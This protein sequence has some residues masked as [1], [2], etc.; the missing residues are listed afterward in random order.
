MNNKY[1][2]L[3][4]SHFVRDEN[5]PLKSEKEDNNDR[6]IQRIPISGNTQSIKPVEQEEPRVEFTKELIEIIDILE[7]EG[8]IVAFEMLWLNE[9]FAKYK[10]GLRI[11]KVDVSKVKDCYDVTM[12]NNNV[13]P[14]R[15]QNF[16]NYYWGK[17]YFDGSMIKEYIDQYNTL[18]GGVEAAPKATYQSN[19]QYKS[20]DRVDVIKP[21]G[22]RII[23]DAFKYDPKNVRSTFISLVTKTYPSGHE[24]ELLKFLPKLNKDSVGNYYKV[25]GD[26]PQTMFTCHL[27]TA[28]RNQSTTRLFS[29][30]GADGS[31]M[32]HTDGSTILGADDKAGATILLYMIAYN[33]PG[34]YYFF[35]GEERGGVGSGEISRIYDSITYL[36]NI[37]KCVSFD[38]RDVCSVITSQLGGI[39]CSREF[40]NALCKEFN[41]SG[42]NLSLDS[43]GIYTDS[44][45]FLEQI[46]EC[47]NI[48]VG[49]YSEH[50]GKERQNITFLEKLCKASIEVN[51]DSLPIVR[52]IGIDE[53]IKRKYSGLIADLKSSSFGIEVKVMPEEGGGSVIRCNLENGFIDGTYETLYIL[54]FLL[55]KHKI[56]QSVYFDEEYIKIHLP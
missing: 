10:N 14:M 37:K 46:P 55:K 40:G 20:P 38:R 2:Y 47:T 22:E 3:S 45:S 21:T 49:Y 6:T 7:E 12:N 33:V 17:T 8:S 24:S 41:K 29:T 4:E 50:S 31:E 25:I 32:I 56:S 34:V 19:Y 26:N 16:I 51:W 23:P 42:L 27:D 35:I 39:C 54:Q 5:V 1:K 9:P 15:I 11:R 28:D 18:T 44:A 53:E 36:R 48:S 43:K 30:K 13:H 52:R